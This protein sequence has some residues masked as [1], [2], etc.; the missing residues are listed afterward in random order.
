MKLGRIHSTESFGTVDGPGIRFVI[1]FQGCPMRCR[2]CHNPDTWSQNGGTLRSAGELLAQYRRNR[3]F[4]TG[5]G[6]TATGGEPLAQPDFLLELFTLA[7]QEKIHTCLD[8]SGVTYRPGQPQ[9]TMEAI[10]SRTDLV[11]LDLK[12]MEPTAHKALTGHGNENILAFARH[13]ADRG[14][15]VWARHV[16][17]PGLTDDRTQLEALGA[18]LA[19]LDNVRALEVLPY[20][21]MGIEKYRK[22][23]IA[24]PLADTPPATAAQTAA[25]REIL[26]AAYR[27][28]RGR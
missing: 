28:N 15:P 4:Y 24:D 9:P 18:F 10:L 5:G 11:L 13:L 17:L 14:I 27:R 6:L 2:Y 12:H 26:L 7:K 21:K 25:A 3:D 20:H 19:T 23:G 16:L 8:T 22:L 1:F